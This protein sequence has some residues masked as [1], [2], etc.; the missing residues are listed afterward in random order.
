[1]RS[2]A[3]LLAL[4]LAAV[5]LA[6]PATAAASVHG[7]VFMDYNA[8]GSRDAG[9]FVAGTS[10]TATD[11]GV[12]GVAVSAYDARGRR[13]ATATT[14][15]DG[16]YTLATAGS[17]TV[18]IQFGTPLGYAPSLVGADS[19]SSVR[20][21]RANAAAAIDYAIT[22]GGDYCQDNPKLVTCVMPY[23]ANYPVSAPGA[24]SLDSALGPLTLAQ[25]GETLGGTPAGG[26]ALN[27]PDDMGAVWGVG[28]DRAG[29]AY[30]GTYV[31]RHSPYGPGGDGTN[32]AANWIYQVDTATGATIP[33]VRLGINTLP[34][35]VAAAPVGWPEYSADG[36][37]DDG[38][39]SDVFHLVGRAGLGDVDVAPD[40]A[41][42]YAVEMTQADPR[43]WSV[44]IVATG[45]GAEAGEPAAVGIP[46][47]TSLGGVSCEGQWH[48]MGLDAIAG[49]VLVG[50]VC[51]VEK[52]RDVLAIA[53]TQSVAGG[54]E[55]PGTSNMSVTFSTPHGLHVGDLITLASFNR[56]DSACPL[57]DVWTP[58][59][60]FEVQ[61]VASADTI[62]IDTGHW[63]CAG[64]APASTTGAVALFAGRQLSAFVLRYDLATR[65]FTSIAAVGLD[66]DKSLSAENFDAT[67]LYKYDSYGL[68]FDWSYKR[69]GYWRTWNDWDPMPGDL[70][71]SAAPQPLLANVE[72]RANG[73]LV[74]GFRDRWLDQT[75]AAYPIDYDSTAASPQLSQSYNASADILVLCASGGGYVMERGG[76]CGTATGASMPRLLDGET[77]PDVR[78]NSPL[79]FWN[80]FTD[81]I[82]T[83]IA[84]R[85]AYTGQGGIALMPGGPLWSTAYDIT[86]INQQGVRAFGPCPARSGDGSCGPAGA[87]D[88]AILGGTRFSASVSTS[89]CGANCWG[90]GNGLGDLEVVCDAA[91]L[92]IGDRVWI[93]ANRDG[94]QTADEAAVAGVTVHLY[95]ATGTLVGTAITDAEGRYTFSSNVSAPAAG[96]GSSAGG[97]L[98]AGAAYTIRLDNPADHAAGGPLAG[99]ELTTPNVTRQGASVNSKATIA[100]GYP[101]IAVA[102]RT[103]GENA[104]AFDVGFAAPRDDLVAIGDRVWV[105]ANRDGRQG[106]RPLKGVRVVLLTADGRRA[107]DAAG[108]LVPVRTTGA[109]GAY[110][111]DGLAPGV[112]RVRF[113]LPVGYRFTVAGRPGARVNSD[114]RATRANPLVGVT[115]A[116]R[117][118]D[119]AT[120][121]TIAS[122][123]TRIDAD[124]IDPTIDAGVVV[125][126]QRTPGAT[127]VT[128]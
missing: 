7:T 109:R 51:E 24:V 76:A 44:P 74:L 47:P 77:N 25:H 92:Q 64:L 89:G 107:R 9:G 59:N 32:G 125:A 103:A 63:N 52:P 29:N 94:I 65:A 42:V 97:G 22:S 114:P 124:W 85:H 106:E 127:P 96:D 70:S 10:A 95:D 40:G 3:R 33:W 57:N 55:G 54:S 27:A 66:Y 53:S 119:S 43:L 45:T 19:A 58:T 90:K 83:G 121:T 73:D 86:S 71:L 87:A 120:G 112:Y 81:S 111:F 126:P 122:T 11:S 75:A 102:A 113:V 17:A 36:Y 20:F 49:A 105:D 15:A 16:S 69:L 12:A 62:V 31:K 34:A 128:G 26:T 21:V 8:N 110:L 46:R 88:G 28:V 100:D 18:R 84:V 50:G 123:S 72:M 80:G 48:P 118:H 23:L 93:D 56:S 67:S 99:Y 5:G 14:A 79:Y 13:V 60:F 91:P 117:V 35:H 82:S 4:A 61:E 116:F 104:D 101:Q 2:V 68:A 108:R 98:A 37:R 39:S 6:V 1:M 41:T 30:Y 78:A 38:D 115:P